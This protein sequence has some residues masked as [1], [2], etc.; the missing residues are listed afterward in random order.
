VFEDAALSAV[1]PLHCDGQLAI[2]D[3]L[4][5]GRLTH[6]PIT[7]NALNKRRIWGLHSSAAKCIVL[8]IEP[9]Q[10]PRYC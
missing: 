6:R 2:P 7:R 4:R 8:N 1:R 10:R 9:P 5:A 3:Q